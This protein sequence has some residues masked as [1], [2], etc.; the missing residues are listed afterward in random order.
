[1]I[2]CSPEDWNDWLEGN[3]TLSIGGR[4][5]R[6][7]LADLN[8]TSA[9]P[10]A[11][12]WALQHGTDLSVEIEGFDDQFETSC[13]RLRG[14][15]DRVDHLVLDESLLER[16]TE[17]GLYAEGAEGI[18][19]F[20][21]GNGP[22]AK[23]FIIIRDIKTIEGPK[24]GEDGIRHVA[25]LFKEI[26]LALYARAWEL[27][28]PGDRVIGVGISEVGDDTEHLVELDPS[29]AFLEEGRAIGTRTFYSG[30]HF[31]IP[32]EG[33]TPE[34]NSFRSWMSSRI[35]AAIR[36]QDASELG[37]NHPAPGDHCKY[38][39]LARACSS[40]SIGGETK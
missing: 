15:I 7:L 3:A 32:T 31:R 16:L 8:L 25:G 1:M 9:A 27:A 33:T 34:S 20:F 28:H 36:A 2:G 22:P 29:F 30:N 35:T 12:E 10:I 5:G 6:L 26:Q 40:A 19:L 38:C 13:I 11:S 14:R 21:D 39:S 23:R 24:P 18:P 4:L 17:R 37:W